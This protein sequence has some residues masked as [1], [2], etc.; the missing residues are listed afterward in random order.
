MTIPAGSSLN[1]TPTTVIR[2]IV[3]RHAEEAAFLWSQRDAATD[4]PHYALRHLALL[5]ERVEAQLDGLRVAGEAGVEAAWANLDQLQGA[6]ELF[7]VATLAL[8]SRT[9]TMIESVLQFAEAVPESRRGLFGALGWAAPETLR[10]RVVNWLDAPVP[11]RR[12][13]GVVACSLHRADPGARMVKLLGDDPV[14][15]ARALRLAGEL[16]RIDLRQHIATASSD[17]E[18]CRFWAAWSAGLLADR[19]S[20]IPVLQAHAVGG[21]P[22]K[23]R[24]L[25]LVVRLMNREAAIGWLRDLGSDP[26]NARLVVIAAGILG[27]PVVVPWL[28]ERMRDPELARIAGESFSTITARDLS[29]DGLDGSAPEGFTAGPNDDPA[30]ENVA[31]DPDENLQWPDP[32][33]VQG[34]WQQEAGRFAQSVRHLRGLPL[35]AQAC[36]ATLRDG[37]QRQR[38]AAA[39][40]RALSSPGLHLWNWREK[41]RV[42]AGWLH[43][44]SSS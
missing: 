9:E 38:R 1:P 33:K 18:A 12:L 13:L 15:R 31:I 43:A 40:E 30:S 27:D 25:D 42:Q 26:A 44:R 17:D 21:G 2:G 22:F 6:G 5:E 37:Y 8:E 34:W 14:V 19:P 36:S 29:E 4:Q 16:G 35:T 28:I 7:A 24:A 3:Q 10:G 41:S 23:W 11:F 32:A 20:A 39:Y